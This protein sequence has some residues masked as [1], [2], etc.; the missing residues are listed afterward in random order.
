[1]EIGGPQR[2]PMNTFSSALRLVAV[3]AAFALSALAQQNGVGPDSVTIGVFGPISGPASYIGLAG[4]DGAAL[5]FKEV[6]DAGGI[7]GRKI[8]MVF[9]DDA[10]SPA[11]AVAA[12]KKLVEQDKV[13][14]LMS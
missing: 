12:A 3:L 13:F 2:R 9:E 5:A 14:M 8:R 10:H 11:R 7:N 6:N 4:R 1:M